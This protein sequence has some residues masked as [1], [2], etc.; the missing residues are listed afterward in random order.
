MALREDKLGQTWLIPPSINELIPE[1]HICHLIVSL[2][3]NLDF[4]SVDEKYRCTRGRPAY[5]RKMLLRLLLL[6]Y[7]NCVFSS[8]KIAKLAEENVIFMYVT[9]GEKPD[10]RTICNFKIECKYLFAM[11]FLETV[12]F[13][14]SLGM[15]K[16][17][18]LPID[19]T[20]I[21]ANASNQYS[22]GEEELE[23]VGKLIDKGILV[24]VE[25][26]DLYGDE[27]G[28]QLPPGSKSK[29]K[30]MIEED[31]E[32]EG[33]LHK[34]GWN[35][36]KR[37][38]K[39]DEKE[40]QKVQETINQAKEELNKSKQDAVS[41]SDPE[42]R[43]MKNKKDHTELSYNYQVAV[44]GDSGII[45]AGVVS[46]DPT[47]HKLLKPI[48]GEVEKNLGPLPE[49]TKIPVDNGYFSGENLNY[50]EEKGLDGYIPNKKQAGKLKGKK[51]KDDP[52]S[53]DKF[54]Y[55]PVKDQFTCPETDILTRKGKY[56]NKRTGKYF[57][58]YYGANCRDCPVKL[59][60]TGGKGRVKV[61]SCNEYEAERQ[62]MA[63]KMETSDAK[64]AYRKRNIVE[65]PFGNIKYNMKYTE[66][67]TRGLSKVEVEKDLLNSVNNLKLI[68][69][70]ILNATSRIKGILSKINYINPK[71]SY[72]I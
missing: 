54:A 18:D 67:F 16:L 4:S 60:C 38:A 2:V 8:R 28:D 10:F 52:Y 68:W 35:L 69:K 29:I 42:S 71:I 49:G 39:G 14:R 44:D 51:C 5:S 53:K 55:D 26:D 46:Q 36:L 32:F 7:I 19:G 72:A 59:E 31:D 62:R 24:D 56:F 12:Y 9:G 13:A 1:N 17:G 70:K 45:M 47:D 50:M 15:V 61:I 34:A 64:E 43:Y 63:L 30:E 23:L 3:D 41:L 6:A 58:T 48:I 22:I 25:E 21:K 66:F 57:H 40:K 20:I 37:H 27:R 65:R 11:A 33:K